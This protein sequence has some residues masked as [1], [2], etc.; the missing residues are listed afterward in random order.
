MRYFG[1]KKTTHLTEYADGGVDHGA[2]LLWSQNVRDA[3]ANGDGFWSVAAFP[4]DDDPVNDDLV[5][6]IAAAI[7]H[8]HRRDAHHDATI[9]D[10]PPLLDE[11]FSALDPLTICHHTSHQRLAIDKDGLPSLFDDL[12]ESVILAL[13]WVP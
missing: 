12:V 11:K 1:L 3:A 9:D 7:D 4:I 13:D 10:D 2:P 5:N 8:G 6:D